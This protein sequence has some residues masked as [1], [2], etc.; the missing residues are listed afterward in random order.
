MRICIKCRRRKA[1]PPWPWPWLLGGCWLPRRK[2]TCRM[3]S[4][5]SP[6]DP[7]YHAADV[8]TVPAAARVGARQARNE[9][10]AV[11]AWMRS[12]PAPAAA[13]P[14]GGRPAL[15]CPRR[16]AAAAC[17]RQ[18][19]PRTRSTGRAGG[20]PLHPADQRGRRRLRRLRRLRCWPRRLPPR[21]GSASSA[22]AASRRRRVRCRAASPTP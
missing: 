1:S 6:Q 20:D 4:P 8:V 13:R 7:P 19:A 12:A 17:P 21:G 15:W 5:A 9:G 11:A 16:A 10:A 2:H 14:V 3:P 18:R 22:R